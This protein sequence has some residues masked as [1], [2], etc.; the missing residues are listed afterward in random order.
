MIEPVPSNS[1][2]TP[3]QCKK[4]QGYNHSSNFCNYP[5]RCVKCGGGHL[6]FHCEKPKFITDPKC[7]NC[8][9][10]HAASYR[11][12]LIAK[13]ITEQRKELFKKIEEKKAIRTGQPVPLAAST[14]KKRVSFRDAFRNDRRSFPK[15]NKYA[16]QE[17][18]TENQNEILVNEQGTQNRHHQIDLTNFSPL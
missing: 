5:P 17:P 4:C 12:C 8:G 7:A 16:N 1:P 13:T 11:G 9:G 18:T 15:L 3:V 2:L 14:L 6:S 10:N